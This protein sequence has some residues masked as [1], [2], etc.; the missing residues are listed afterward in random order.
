MVTI[1][2]LVRNLTL[3]VAGA[4]L[5]ASTVLAANTGVLADAQARYRQ[6]MA[7]CNKGNSN[8]DLATCRLEA[9]NALAEA[10]RGSLNDAPGQYQQ[11]ALKRCETHK[12]ED[13]ADCEAR[14]RGQGS[15]EGSAASGGLLRES[16]TI[17]PGK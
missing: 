10:R 3:A 16:V 5:G 7:A 14:M 2:V 4:V 1:P 13:R 12:G 8:Q 15:V 6:D 9:K 17:E 11:N